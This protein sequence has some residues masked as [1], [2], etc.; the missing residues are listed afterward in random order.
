MIDFL[1]GILEFVDEFLW[2]FDLQ[3]IEWGM[4]FY[5]VGDSLVFLFD[6]VFE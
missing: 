5:F 3:V 1:V 2:L 6:K 4:F